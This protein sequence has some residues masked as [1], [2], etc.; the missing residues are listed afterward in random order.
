MYFF[1]ILIF[2]KKNLFGKLFF[3]LEYLGNCLGKVLNDNCWGLFLVV[4][5][6]EF[7][8]EILVEKKDKF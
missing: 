2:Y 3:V 8:V 5:L 7:N 1:G 4:L 6:C